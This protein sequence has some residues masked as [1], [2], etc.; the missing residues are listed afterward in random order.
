MPH[1]SPSTIGI[2]C[3]LRGE[4]GAL[5]ERRVLERRVLGIPIHELDDLEPMVGPEAEP[6]IGGRRAQRILVV[7]A[8]VGKVRSAHA[9]A[10]LLAAGVDRALLV[11]GTCGALTPELSIGDFVHAASAVDHTGD[12]RLERESLSDPLLFRA[13][14]DV[15]AGKTARFFSVDRAVTSFLRRRT[16]ARSRSGGAAVDMETAAAALVAES[17]GV[18]WAA[19]RVV[20]D[21]AGFMA[22]SSFKKHF[23]AHG[24]RAAG[25]LPEFLR[26]LR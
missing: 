20:T 19:L 21:R 8:G 6:T 23:A 5:A 24:A 1:E 13:W 3:A 15:A 10:A 17:A 16:I 22:E 14:A 18:P 12:A 4:L 7:V 9:A 26:R 11:V 25:T 2:L